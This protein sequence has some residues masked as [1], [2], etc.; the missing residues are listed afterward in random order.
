MVQR[1]QLARIVALL[2]LCHISLARDIPII[3]TP[4][5]VASLTHIDAAIKDRLVR[6]CKGVI[7]CIDS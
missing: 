6:A 3:W 7:P 4:E 1:G 5:G 2:A